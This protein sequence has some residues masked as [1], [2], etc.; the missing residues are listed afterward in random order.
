MRFEGQVGELASGQVGER[1]PDNASGFRFSHFSTFMVL[2]FRFGMAIFI[3]FVN[4]YASLLF[5][6]RIPEACK[7]YG[8]AF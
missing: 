8:S 3:L 2:C 6:S 1:N 5:G 7:V 4:P